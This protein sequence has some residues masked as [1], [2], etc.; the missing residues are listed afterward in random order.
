MVTL[1]ESIEINSPLDV[2]YGW[3]I[4][5]DENFVKWS[6]CHTYFKKA[7]G[8]FAVGDKICF[9]ERVEGVSYRI[10]GVIRQHEKSE[11]GFRLVFE[12]MSGL[13]HI[14][15]IGGKTENGC[16]FTHIEEFGKPNTRKGR[17][18]NHLLFDILAKRR[19][20]WRL[21]QDD[22]ARDNLHLKQILETGTYPDRATHGGK[23]KQ[24]KRLPAEA[25]R[26]TFNDF[27]S[28]TNFKR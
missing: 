18:I 6:P 5:L 8:R 12:T 17:F 10:T 14:Y 25:R 24:T 3:L 26:E 15:F 13:S 9:G 1:I 16:S 2:L 27:G 20:N 28:N 7:T 19:A 23:K 11:D 22:M 4:K 21:I